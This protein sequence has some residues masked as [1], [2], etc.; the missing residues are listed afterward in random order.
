LLFI[1]LFNFLYVFV[2]HCMTLCAFIFLLLSSKSCSKLYSNGFSNNRFLSI[3]PDSCIFRFS[4][5]I[6]VKVK[7]L[8]I[9]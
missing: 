5:T 2:F 3:F 8:F 9:S 7:P 4:N 6:R 1:F